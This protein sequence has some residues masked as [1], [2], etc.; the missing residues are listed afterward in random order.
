MLEQIYCSKRRMRKGYTLILEER[1]LGRENNEIRGLCMPM[2]ALYCDSIAF[3]L[4][5]ELRFRVTV[6]CYQE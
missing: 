4:V 1:S 5:L 6:V 3:V 2:I